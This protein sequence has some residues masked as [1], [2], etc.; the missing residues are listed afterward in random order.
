MC[1]FFPV[2]VDKDNRNIHSSNA[3][4]YSPAGLLLDAVF[5]RVDRHFLRDP[6]N[7]VFG[8]DTL[9]LFFQEGDAGR[10]TIPGS[11]LQ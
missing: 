7:V 6:P 4:A 11:P 2:K 1:S 3:L 9:N 5:K 8:Q 10:C